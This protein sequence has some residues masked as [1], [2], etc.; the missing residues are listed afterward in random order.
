MRFIAA[1]LSVACLA[2][3]ST[4]ADIVIPEGYW[5]K[6][7]Y[8]VPH[9]PN[10]AGDLPDGP[11][12][13]ATWKCTK[14]TKPF[15]YWYDLR[16]KRWDGVTEKQIKAAFN[17]GSA[18]MSHWRF[19]SW[20]GTECGSDWEGKKYCTGNYTEWHATS[21]IPQLEARETVRG[22]K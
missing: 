12:L 22:L 15:E 9:P 5:I 3:A 10:M 2:I 11:L 6:E 8:P 16:G 7:V 20:N 14:E 19:V 18:M 1:L 4:R 17:T 21:S 13:N